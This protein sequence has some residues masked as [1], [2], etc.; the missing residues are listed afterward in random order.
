MHRITRL[1]LGCLI[2]VGCNRPVEVT[3]AV[4]P[5]PAEVESSPGSRVNTPAYVLDE[6]LVKRKADKIV[7]VDL[8]SLAGAELV[9]AIQAVSQLD[10]VEEVSLA[11]EEV[12]DDLLIPITKIKTL[13]RLRLPQTKV[14]DVSLANLA[15]VA[16]LELLDLTDVATLTENGMASIGKLSKLKE[17]NLMNTPVTDGWLSP[18]TELTQLKK[19]RLRGTQITGDN[20]TAM[21]STSVIDLEL[22]ETK[23]GS[24]GMQAIA[25]MPKLERLNLWLTQVDDSGLA[26]LDGKT[27]LTLL[28]LDNVAG[29]TDASMPVIEKLVSL[30]LLHL[31]GTG[32]T[33]AS[34]PQLASL[35]QLKTLF[36]T[37][38]N[39][40]QE[41]AKLLK[42]SLP[43]LERFEF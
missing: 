23:F 8:K 20:F 24:Q 19:L 18:L 1:L 30:E 40:S 39:L 10:A 26:H 6:S 16:R 9:A 34:I 11:G 12:N 25:K 42:M 3:T 14:G 2:L 28:N 35:T 32:L 4:Q 27:S 7:S 17:L 29:V 15:T 21:A 22:S 31:G 13:K 33:E 41:T 5:S 37:R 38:L 43:Q 36:L